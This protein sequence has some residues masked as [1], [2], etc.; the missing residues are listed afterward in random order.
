MLTNALT[1][2]TH[3]AHVSGNPLLITAANFSTGGVGYAQE[4]PPAGQKYA[5]S[6]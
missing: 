1:A 6:S 3:L 5:V 4:F 2:T